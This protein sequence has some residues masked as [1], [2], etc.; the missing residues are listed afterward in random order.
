V[1]EISW[2]AREFLAAA[3]ARPLVLVW[4]DLH[5]ASPSLLD[6]ISSITQGLADYPVLMIYVTRPELDAS[7]LERPADDLDV[8]PLARPD[9][10]EFVSSLTTRLD[11]AEVT[12]HEMDLLERIADDSGGYP[13]YAELLVETLALGHPPGEMPPSITALVGAMLDRLPAPSRETLEAASVI[14]TTFTLAQVKQLDAEPTPECIQELV[15]RQLV[16]CGSRPGE[17]QFA[18]QLVHEVVYGRLQKQQR[19]SWH[20]R[21]ADLNVAPE[22]HLEAA[23]RLLRE[24]RPDDPDLPTLASQAADALVGEGTFA[25]RQRDLPAAIGLLARARD[26]A[27]GNGAHQRALAAIR[28]S[29]ALLLS[30]NLAEAC[31]VVTD[32]AEG[33]SSPRASRA[34]RVQQALVAIRSGQTTEIS[35]DELAAEL[36]Q[37][38]DDHVSWCRFHQLQMLANLADGQFGAAEDA[39]SAALAHARAMGDAYEQDRLLAAACEVGQWSPVPIHDK[40]AACNELCSR[41]AADRFLLV[42]MLAAKARFLALTGDLAGARE[43]LAETAQIVADLQMTIG[44]ILVEQVSGLVSS[45]ADDPVEARRHYGR[46]AEALTAAG[47]QTVALTMRVFALREEMRLD[48]DADVAGEMEALAA[49]RVRMDMRGRVLHTALAARTATTGD[50]AARVV[51]EVQRLLDNTDDPVL[52]GDAYV[53]LAREFR[54]RGDLARCQTMA[55]AARASYAAVGATLPMS[56]VVACR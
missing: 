27:P 53:E 49:E 48:G 30:G 29:D 22:F 37:D 21:L 15:T 39:V 3:A 47:H 38:P 55:D 7:W 24:I 16:Q 42:P 23:V 40:L 28:L 46:A 43:T 31:A 18:Q 20:R 50:D 26:I 8:G 1:E 5:W 10:L 56:K 9:T 17:Y 41:F 52:H 35:V 12:G 32:V 19:L 11:P 54:H 36:E 33:A 6:L 25:L 45:L 2:A 13:L 4:E 51:E 34:C 14:G 44:Q